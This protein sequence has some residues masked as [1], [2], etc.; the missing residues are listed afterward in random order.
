M[1]GIFILIAIIAGF[2]N[3][4]K[5]RNLN[6]IL[7]AVLSIVSWFGAQFI[8]ALLKI[9]IDPYSSENELIV[10]GLVGSVIGIAILFGIM[11]YAARKKGENQQ[12]V[13]DEIM[14]DVTL[15]DL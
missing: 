2:Y 8:A 9:T 11:H 5:K 7:Y 13:S 12:E 10:V 1:L 6:G 15:D 14:D 3:A 4:A